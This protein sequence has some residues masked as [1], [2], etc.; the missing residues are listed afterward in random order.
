[1]P[2]QL[3]ESLA[4]STQFRS[5]SASFCSSWLLLSRRL[6]LHRLQSQ[7]SPRCAA[8]PALRSLRSPRLASLGS[9]PSAR[10]APAKQR[11]PRKLEAASLGGR[12]RRENRSQ[13]KQK[14][15]DRLRNCV[16]PARLSLSC[17]G[18]AGIAPHSHESLKP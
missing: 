14:L 11:N 13:D 15:A 17:K 2:L 10:T 12:K 3:K 16:E 7:A 4:G 6:C 8:S 9:A 5:R 1:M 18:K